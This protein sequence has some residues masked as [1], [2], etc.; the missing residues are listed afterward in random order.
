MIAGYSL[1]GM[2]RRMKGRGEGNLAV[3]EREGR[4]KSAMIRS[5]LSSVFPATQKILEV[6]PLPKDGDHELTNN[7]RPVSLLP[8][9]SK[10][11]ER[12]ALN[13]L[14]S[15]MNKNNRLTEHRSGNK[16]MHSCETFNVLMT[17][18]TLE[19]IDLKN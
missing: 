7:D 9:A 3:R 13:Q 16:A 4:G 1:R 10:I 17:D 15:Y 6:G 14:I 2:R 18:K 8:T 11:C 19:A 12:I 5:L